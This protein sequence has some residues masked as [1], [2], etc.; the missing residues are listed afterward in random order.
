MKFS[1]S[2]VKDL[3]LVSPTQLALHVREK[4]MGST[5]ISWTMPLSKRRLKEMNLLSTA[6]SIQISMARRRHKSMNSK[7]KN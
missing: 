1:K 6:K 3:D 4:S 2:I 7:N 5:I